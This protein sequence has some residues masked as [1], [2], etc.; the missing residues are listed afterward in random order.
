[1]NNITYAVDFETFYNKTVS[2][3]TLG[4][5]G[6]FS[7]PEFDS[8]LVSVVGSDG[9]EFVGHPEKWD[10]S[11]LKGCTVLSHN[12]SFDETLYKFGVEKGWYPAVE[13]DRWCCTADMAAYL[14]L[15]RNLAGSSLVALG[16]KPDKSTRGNMMNKR[17]ENMTDEFQAEV[18]EYALV[19]SRLCLQLWQKLADQWPDSEKEISR[20]N[21]EALQKGIP[22]DQAALRKNIESVKEYLFDAESAIPWMG[23]KKTLS[24]VAFNDECRKVGIMPPPSL[25][26]DNPEAVKWIAEHGAK[27][28]WVK[29]VGEWRR[30][31]AMLKKLEAIDQATMADGRYYGNIMYWGGHTG[32]FSG[33]GGNLNLQN[34]PKAD[35]FGANLRHLIVPKKGKKLIVVDLSQIEVRTLLWLAGDEETMQEVRK[36]DD[37]YEAFAIM[38]GMWDPAKGSLKAGDNDLRQIVK[39]IVLGSGFMAGPTAFAAKYGYPEEEAEKSISMYRTKMKKIV[40]FWKKLKQNIEGSMI[41]GED[42]EEELP[43]GRS[44]RYGKLKKVKQIV[45]G[46]TKISNIAILMKHSKRTPVRIWQGLVT[47]N[48]AQALARDIFADMMVRIEHAGHD[49][50]FHVHDELILEVDEN[51]AD[52]VLAE[53]TEIMSVPPAWIPDIPLSAEGHVMNRYDK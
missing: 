12:A 10:W 24:R 53:V 11:M 46:K 22:I 47:E 50:L 15:P 45:N 39:A 7:H 28:Q 38:F 44:M 19:D 3:K 35:M 42:L 51:K 30:I 36:T 17:W 48:L 31:N 52:E 6:Y 29:S 37:I 4:P 16:I 9:Y 49:I 18:N 5:R 34:L 41:V 13:Y 33:G 26:Q 40:A 23:E 2:I 8:Y 27:Y 32:R 43:S 25:A 14:G 20:V 1:M 21:R